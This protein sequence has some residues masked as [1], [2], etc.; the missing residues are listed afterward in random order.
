MRH[1]VVKSCEDCPMYND[2]DCTH[3]DREGPFSEPLHWLPLAC[4]LRDET[5]VIMVT[6][7]KRR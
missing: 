3:P 4:P 1:I 6:E 5:L 2:G 7:E